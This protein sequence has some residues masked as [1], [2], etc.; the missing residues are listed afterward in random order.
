MSKAVE[1]HV[2]G[3]LDGDSGEAGVSPFYIP[4]TGTV[5]TLHSHVLKQADSFAVLD[6]FGDVQ[7]SKAA[8]EG[9]FFEDT[10]YLARLALTV[11]GLRPL[12]LSSTVTED[13][14]ML[15]TDLANPDL[16]EEGHLRLAR[17][18]VHILRSTVLGED[19]LFVHLELRNFGMMPVLLRLGL[20]F[21]ADFADI[22]EVRGSV[23]PR[24]GDRF[25]DQQR[26]A[27][28]V[29][30]YRGLD[31]VVR[32]TCFEFDP[33]PAKMAARRAEWTVDLPAGGQQTI[34][35][36]V[37]C[38]RDGRT[39]S[40]TTSHAT[41][42]TTAAGRVADRKARAID[43]YSS[44]ETFND[45]LNRSRADLDMLITETPQ[46]LYAYA[47][48]PW[49]ST[50]FGRDGIIT[51]LQCLWL[52]PTLAVGTL[53]FLA[54]SQA[55][56]L[57]AS[58]DAEP[59]KILHETRK[60][61][62]AA[63]GEVPFGRYYG[64]IDSTPL[65]IMLA[66]AYYAR[67]GDIDLVR[68]L[69]PNIEAALAWMHEYGD[70]DGDGFLEY[71]RKSVNGLINQGWKDSAD[72]IFHA[73]GSLAEAPIALA[74]V[75]AYAYAAYLG[76]AKLAAALGRTGT[77]GELT[78]LA[79]R[80]GARFEAAFWVESLG[81]YALALDGAKRPCQVR[82]SNA[83]HVLF[84]GLAGPERAARVAK[85]LMTP[86]FFSSWGIRTVAKG[87]A[88]YNPISYHNGSVWPHDNGLIAMGFAR[89][90]L[91]EPLLRVLT[92]LFDAALF[93]DLRRLPELFCGFARRPGSGPTA[94]PVA[95]IPQAWS[96]ASV[97]ALLG[98]ALGISFAPEAHQ[99]RFVRP[100]LPPWLKEIRLTNL[101]LGAASAD[102]VLSRSQESVAIH[103]LRQD[104]E[105]GI[106]LAV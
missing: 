76:A 88:R 71:D 7:A 30:V 44:N 86:D 24:R 98:A 93:L 92:G 94:Y 91:K 14:A 54:A 33:P 103:V 40:A 99:I 17:D 67:T 8:P 100:V 26:T 22:F 69:W 59:G 68:T 45:W 11:D 73:D 51:A 64:S 43:L 4:S 104:G 102:L 20:A 23:R 28:P 18:T 70:L 82:A 36:A 52:D 27:G 53:R 62:M 60:S 41:S 85:A 1:P 16:A 74:E 34:Q 66:A 10:R 77:A 96:S 55:T 75:Q 2:A 90:G 50:P 29:L 101:R 6:D 72:S 12:L 46:G 9:L 31:A 80:L 79:Q 32:R 37:R 39:P 38:E 56:R 89:Y 97:F 19:A 65:F 47:G 58:A 5:A 49:F 105:L 106:V 48:I 78:M 81:T 61:E 95:C 57:D 42:L 15:S 63:L 21:D 13:N 84:G 25:P 83:G 3:P 35:C 87:E